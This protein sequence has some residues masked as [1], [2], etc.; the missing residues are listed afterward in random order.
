M[1]R[2]VASDMDGTLL[3]PWGK[4]SPLNIA[5]IEA[6]RRKNI[7]FVVCTGRGFAD[8]SLPLKEAGVSCDIIC[9]NGAAVFDSFGKQLR[10]QPMSKKQ[11][12]R[13]LDICRSFPVLYDFMAE[14][15]SYT[16]SDT[17][18]FRKSFE[19]GIFL[20]MVSKEHTYETIAQR[21]QF[22]TE[23]VLLNSPFDIYKMSVVHGN[24]QVLK[25]LR[26][27]LEQEEELS[28]AS[29]DSSNL[30]LTHAGAQKGTALLEYAKNTGIQPKEI[31]A[32]GDSEND[33]SM[34]KLP[35]GY[36]VAMANAS[37]A[38]KRR[39]RL[40]TR[41]NNAD[42]VAAAIEA[43]ILSDAAAAG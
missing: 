41:S 23:E 43:L 14:S 39:A 36:T 29:S 32:I 24:P 16:T 4:I 8:A 26:L 27:F 10:K 25:H 33:L 6:L 13:I 18:T 31:L 37:E 11:I 19:D 12:S 17:E 35:L 20:P 3:N 22:T 5:A 34:L 1:I 21:F 38:V 30:E 42:G 9:M 7:N 28:V 2:L 15:G 40:M